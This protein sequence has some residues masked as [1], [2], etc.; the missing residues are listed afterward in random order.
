[1]DTTEMNDATLASIV[2]GTFCAA[3]THYKKV[4][5]YLSSSTTTKS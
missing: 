3:G 5:L 4:T 1:M 2:G